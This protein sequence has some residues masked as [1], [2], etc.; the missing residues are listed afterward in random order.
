[1]ANDQRIGTDVAELGQQEHR[2]EL[3]EA[4]FVDRRFPA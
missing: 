2:I 4:I 3:G 1:M